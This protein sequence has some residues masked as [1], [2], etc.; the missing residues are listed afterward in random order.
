MFLRSFSLVSFYIYSLK[1]LMN[2]KNNE[3]FE[4]A[5]RNSVMFTGLLLKNVKFE[6]RSREEI[7]VKLYDIDPQ[8]VEPLSTTSI[9]PVS[10]I[11]HEM[12]TIAGR[13]YVS[14]LITMYKSHSRPSIFFRNNNINLKLPA[15]E[16]KIEPPLN[17]NDHS[18]GDLF[19]LLCKKLSLDLERV[20]EP[21]LLLLNKSSC[22]RSHAAATLMFYKFIIA[23]PM[24]DQKPNF[25]KKYIQE[26]LPL[27]NQNK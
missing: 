3:K 11:S 25:I 22:T 24:F 15:Q 2:D 10:P 7:L 18:F 14:A 6:Y 4:D 19:I 9:E 20:L 12:K 17:V 13:S 21:D 27:V 1:N 8:Y 16:I 26:I 23:S 5:V